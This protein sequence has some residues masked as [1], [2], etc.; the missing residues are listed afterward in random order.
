M[1]KS[2]I[3]AALVLAALTGST[4]SAASAAASKAAATAVALPA[5]AAGKGQIV[6]WRPGGIGG[7]AIRCTV[8]ENGQMVGRVGPG[9]YFVIPAEPGA[10]K[11]TT[12]TEATDELNLEVEA[13]ET[14]YVKCKIA[15]GMMAGRPNMSPSNK[16][17]FDSKAG[18]L[19]PVDAAEMAKDIA[20]DAA[21][22]A[23]GTAK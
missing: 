21:E 15:M 17:E 23:A 11:F 5:P 12:K 8:R 3:M 9:R 22:R 18:K 6:F 13:D 14:T 10:H 2:N 16:A 7:A 19:K 1:T 20:D 4:P